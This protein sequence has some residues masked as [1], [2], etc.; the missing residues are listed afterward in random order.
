M[1]ILPFLLKAGIII[2]LKAV[3]NTISIY[4][5]KQKEI[6]MPLMKMETSAKVPAEKKEKLIL[7][8]SRILADVTGKPEA[9]TMVTLAE[10]TASMGG[11][12]SSAAFAD[13]RGIGGLNQKV[14]EGISKQVADLLKAELNIAPENIYLTFTEVATTNWGWKGGTFG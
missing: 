7:S 5:H 1:L 4:K 8:L 11:K 12:L 3:V 6:D 2:L 10:T 9:Y 13:V 14:N